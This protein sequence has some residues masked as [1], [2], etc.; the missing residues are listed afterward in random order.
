M[1]TSAVGHLAIQLETPSI[2]SGS[3]L[4]GIIHFHLLSDIVSDSLSVKISGK[5]HCSWDET[6]ETTDSEGKSSRTTTTYTGKSTVIKQILP[7]FVFERGEIKAGDYSFPFNINTPR[8]LPSTFQYGVRNYVKYRINAILNG[9]TAKIKSS[10]TEIGIINSQISMEIRS[11]QGEI[12]AKIATWC[13]MR[14]GKVKVTGWIE[15]NAY[16]PGEIVHVQAGI[17]NSRSMLRVNRVKVRVFREILLRSKEGRTKMAKE[18][19]NEGYITRSVPIGALISSDTPLH[20]SLPLLSL[21]KSSIDQTPTHHGTHINCVY[22]LE[23]LAEMDGSL[24]CG[25]ETPA[26]SR[27]II[28]WPRQ[29]P[30]AEALQAP[31]GWNPVVMS[32]AHLTMTDRAGR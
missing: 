13:C 2:L 30:G 15:K 32:S 6:S 8:D 10:K 4:T 29:L 7:V 16:F 26:F 25:G 19:V 27:E 22:L 12:T 14:K 20:F 24:M 31:G 18:T 3:E 9:T 21:K 1:G 11:L 5:E 17:D 28:V 23:I